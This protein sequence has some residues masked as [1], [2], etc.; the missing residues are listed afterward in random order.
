VTFRCLTDSR[1]REQQAARAAVN[2]V[3]YDD[4]AGEQIAEGATYLE[5]LE[6]RPGLNRRSP[7]VAAS[8][9]NVAPVAAVQPTIN[10]TGGI[11]TP[12]SVLK[13]KNFKNHDP[14]RLPDVKMTT[15]STEE[16]P[17]ARLATEDELKQFI[18]DIRPEDVDI[19]SPEFRALPTE[20]QYEIIGD[21]RVRSRQ[22]S[23]KRLASMLRAAPTALDFSMA[24]IKQLSQRNQLTQQLLTVTDSVGK[25][26]LTIPVRIAA[27]RNREYVL[28]KRGEDDGGGWALGIREGSKAKPIVLE[29][30]EKPEVD[31]EDDSDIE[32]VEEWVLYTFLDQI[33]AYSLVHAN[34]QS[35][36]ILKNTA[37]AK[38][39]K[40]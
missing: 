15:V 9:S 30:D 33:P 16:R 14:Y 1:L 12:E 19:E 21:L 22:Q 7:P 31:D 18:D 40:R 2:A 23:H 37:G 6:G 24:Q 29:A 38:Y 11:G 3:S 10:Q 28:V 8:A 13:K 5:D 17:D 27:E 39:W 20:V 34:S 36:P 25:S 32:E 35:M 4:D 26:H